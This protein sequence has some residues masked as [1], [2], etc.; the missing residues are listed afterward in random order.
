[1]HKL[2][3]S[4]LVMVSLGALA[5]DPS[6]ISPT[7][8]NLPTGP[9]SISGLGESFSPA[10]NSG[11]SS[12]NIPLAVPPGIAGLVPDVSVRYSSGF[13]NGIVGMGRIL[14]MP[15]IQRQTDQG[16]PEYDGTDTYID[17]N[18]SE[19]V[20]VSSNT[21]RAQFSESFA[22][23]TKLDAGWQVSLPNGIQMYL[24]K[25]SS[26]RVAEGSNIF[27]WHLEK[28]QDTNGNLINYQYSSLDDS[29]Q[30]FLSRIIYSGEDSSSA[31]SVVFSYEER[32]DTILSYKPGFE[33]ATRYRLDNITTQSLASNI[34]VYDFEYFNQTDWA[35]QSTLQSIS[36]KNGNQTIELS[37]TEFAYSQYVSSDV[38]I[39]SIPS[40]RYALFGTADTDFI[41]V[42][43]DGLP[44]LINTQPS[45]DQIWLNKGV[46]T[47]GELEWDNIKVMSTYSHDKLSMPNVKWA[48]F[49]GDGKTNLISH[50]S[51]FTAYFHLDEDLNWQTSGIMKDIHLPLDDVNVRLFDINN[52]K[53]VD[54]VRTATK[55]SGQ[56]FAQ[57]VQL[58]LE[59]GWSSPIV[60]DMPYSMQGVRFGDSNVR[61]ADMNGDGLQDVVIIFNK[62]IYFYPG[63]GLKGFGE[64][65]RFSN[66]PR[67]LWDTNSASLVDMNNDGMSDLVYLN[68]IQAQIWINKGQDSSEASMAKF[69]DAAATVI[70]PSG[71]SVRSTTMVDINGNGSTDILWY[72]PGEYEDTF[73]F[74]EL[75]PTEQAN[76]L[77]TISNGMGEETTLYY[78][79]LVDEMIR[80]RE[81]GNAW[82]QGVPI[83]MQVLKR[84]EVTDGISDVVQSTNLDY[85]NGFYHAVEKE[86]RGFASSQDVSSGDASMPSL[87]T[88][89]QY[90]LGQENEVLKGLPKSINVQDAAGNSFLTETQTWNAKKLLDGAA[91]ETRDV[92]FA[93]LTQVDK[94]I[95]E[96]GAGDGV[97]LK[98]EYQYD[99][100]G[101]TTIIKEFGRDGGSW[102]DERTTINRYSS[103][104]ATSLDNWLLTFPIESMV[105]DG[106]D[107][108]VSKQQWFYDDES[109]SGA[110]LGVVTKGNLTLQQA[111]VNPGD[112][113]TTINL[114]RQ[115]YYENGN[116]SDIYGPLWQSGAMGHHTAIQYDEILHTFPV[117]ETMLSSTGN[118][119]ATSSYNTDYGTM[120]SFTDFNN[121]TSTFHYDD[122]GRLKKVVKP[123]DSIDQPTVS[124]DYAINQSVDGGIINWV[125]TKQRE[126]M[127]GGTL[128]SRTF[129]DGLGRTLLTKAEGVHSGQV[130]V[131]NQAQFN[132]RGR[133]FKSYLPYYSSSMTFS[134]AELGTSFTE[135]SF[136]ALGRPLMAW[137]PFDENSQ[138]SFS[139]WQYLPLVQNVFDNEQINTGSSHYGSHKQ[140]VFDGLLNDSG[141]GRLVRVDEVVKLNEEGEE[142]SIT[143]WSTHYEY[144]AVGNFTKLTDAQSNVRTML[145]DGLNRNYFYNDPNRGYFWQAFDAASNVIASRDANG[146]EVHHAFDGVNRVS[147]EY[148][149]TP[150]I[151]T[152]QVGAMWLP[153]QNLAGLTPEV[154]FE[155]DA[156]DGVTSGA[157]LGRL[158][159]VNDAAGY[160]QYKF[161]VRGRVIEQGR[162]I[163]GH[164][165]HSELYTSKRHYDSANRLTRYEYPDTTFID[166]GYDDRGL[167]HSI[168]GVV[169]NLEYNAAGNQTLREYSNG[170]NITYQ[171]DNQL[172]LKNLLATRI[173]DAQILQNL[174]YEFD[175][176][177]N[178]KSITDERSDTS[179]QTL[180]S[181]IQLDSAKAKELKQS[182]AYKYDD[183]YRLSE[184]ESNMVK[185]QYRYDLIGN[186]QER[187]VVNSVK[188]NL[189]TR[190]RY[191]NS[192]TDS[193]NGSWNREGRTKNE[194]A[195][196]HAVT[197]TNG[198][199]N[200]FYDDNGNL[201]HDGQ[202]NYSWD[203]RNR[204][205]QV[206]T[207][208]TAPQA[209]TLDTTPV[210]S[211]G[212]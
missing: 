129:Y 46:N 138:R 96:K 193:N 127:G 184:A 158:V 113:A 137:S 160:S 180:A 91:G 123:G 58:N 38:Q 90:H 54:L 163:S 63:R 121:N 142:S 10:L 6:G 205:I 122:F 48:D 45:R 112:D 34:R 208:A 200:Y 95:T 143:A 116:V 86:F 1:M 125:D 171:Y 128:D 22:L 78:G 57:I 166:Y 53:R 150:T 41:D 178:I 2:L 47:D 26:A 198:S 194:V 77:K 93:E 174:T 203:H 109:F 183:L 20:K 39:E 17:Q 103:E 147:A 156:I 149:L 8:L 70:A 69:A 114:V 82:D 30:I 19:L 32:P 190:L 16:L 175:E 66:T 79:A 211:N 188:G 110:S 72:S 117:S 5:S 24:G 31:Q 152:A 18:G 28:S 176:L 132:T 25:T 204:L 157:S 59:E 206:S 37:K 120:A 155:Y 61:L 133:A 168:S 49:N 44:D 209:S 64:M 105:L 71:L 195:G 141:Q 197:Y 50:N 154:T 102:N 170:V 179:L 51:N 87:M 192:Q 97:S 88:Y 148:H 108:I 196:P 11:T 15:Y 21:Y 62:N 119:T 111:W 135:Q 33:V 146:R 173:N 43:H 55:S 169:N 104:N 68:G 106:N 83:A 172:R 75:F 60:L 40:G 107:N 67:S 140:L 164:G 210:N 202:L 13:G 162:Q 65:V 182:F 100:Y 74:A 185:Y 92:Y 94:I 9:G 177:T 85:H 118:F 101:N 29:K 124:Y 81:A 89:S 99:N 52:D 136:D 134:K 4:I 36:V 165:F 201:S 56:V 189:V 115:K 3:A 73:V 153:T 139:Q 27:S 98:W 42:N 131:G 207:Q 35:P 84:I 199:D 144:D 151:S 167:L 145:Y 212:R 130:I 23:Y 187:T 191:G 126:T 159:K 161:D 14:N 12:Q 7:I 80:D 186:V 181:E 76:Q